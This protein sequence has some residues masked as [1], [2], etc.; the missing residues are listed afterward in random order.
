M[1]VV[2]VTPDSF[3]DG[4]RFLQL[5]QAV[6][7]ARTLIAEGAAIID[8]GG[9]STRPGS[10]PVTLESELARVLPV[11]DALRYDGVPISVDTSKPDVMRQAHRAGADM[12]NDTNAF[13]ADGALAA[14]A[15]TTL[16]LC[17]MHM[18][19]EPRTMQDD[20]RYDD[21]VGEVR[22]FLSE[23]VRAAQAAGVDS[24]RILVDPGF[25][26]GKTLEHNLSLL[27]G[28]GRLADIGVPILVGL[29]RKSM[30]G[31][32]TGRTVDDRGA[33]SVAAALLAV[34]RGARVVRAHDVGAT[35][36]ALAVFSALT[37]VERTGG[38][39]HPSDFSAARP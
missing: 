32:I 18:R 4:G 10:A 16:G 31:R 5:D 26:F 20:P 21:V 36:D 12:I 3:S 19:G 6:A 33:A 13:R 7:H 14:V 24:E 8:I 30:L 11:I 38:G 34:A 23:R 15:G 28:L 35:R 27:A 29:S 22:G 17:I 1:G 37:E 9:E 2:N 39:A 25:G